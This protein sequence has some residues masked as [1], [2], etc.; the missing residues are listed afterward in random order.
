MPD[1]KLLRQYS[2]N[3][4]ELISDSFEGV[5]YRVILMVLMRH[6]R[7][8]SGQESQQQK[9]SLQPMQPIRSRHKGA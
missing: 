3:K 5:M 7:N 4:V 1:G 6:W 9:Y 8:F 2:M